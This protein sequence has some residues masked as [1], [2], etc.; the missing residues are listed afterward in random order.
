M[1]SAIVSRSDRI[2]DRFL[3]PRMFLNRTK[4]HVMFMNNKENQIFKD[5]DEIN[6]HDL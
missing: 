2:S 1:A 6:N 3:V 4:M 5:L